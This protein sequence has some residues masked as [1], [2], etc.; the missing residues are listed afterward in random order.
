MHRRKWLSND[1]AGEMANKNFV[2][3]LLCLK[4]AETLASSIPTDTNVTNL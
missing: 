2:C 1:S 4:V 3:V